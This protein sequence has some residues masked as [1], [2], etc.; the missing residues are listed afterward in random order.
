MDTGRTLGGNAILGRTRRS[1]RTR[2]SGCIGNIYQFVGGV[3]P[4]F[5]KFNF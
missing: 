2:I 5:A 1:A 4:V 3:L